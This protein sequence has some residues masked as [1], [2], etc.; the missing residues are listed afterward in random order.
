MLSPCMLVVFWFA[1]TLAGMFFVLF[2]K[3]KLLY[4]GQVTLKLN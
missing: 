2:N 3:N 4:H 1:R